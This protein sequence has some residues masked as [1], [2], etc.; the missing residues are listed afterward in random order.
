[1]ALALMCGE[2]EDEGDE[3]EKQGQTEKDAGKFFKVDIS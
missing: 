2:D 3:E 1:M